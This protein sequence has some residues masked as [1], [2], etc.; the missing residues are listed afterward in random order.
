MSN[1]KENLNK[2]QQSQI[3]QSKE[4][5]SDKEVI[6]SMKIPFTPTDNKALVKPMEPVYIKK[7]LTEFDE[8]KN[9]G[10]K[11]GPNG[12]V[13]DTKTV[14]KDVK[15]N[16]RRGVILAMPEQHNMS[17]DVG[18]TIVYW[19]KSSLPT[20]ELYRDAVI[21]NHYEILGKWDNNKQRDN[22]IYGRTYPEEDK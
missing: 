9:K 2:T 10:K 22:D 4:I 5:P 19:D 18:D 3:Q 16:V 8:Q 21:L 13:M 20:F 7:E 14:N 1:K 11:K 12:D 15:A 17:F 6:Q